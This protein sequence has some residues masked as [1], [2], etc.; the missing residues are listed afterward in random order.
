[1]KDESHSTNQ[2]SEPI[3]PRRPIATD[4]DPAELDDPNAGSPDKDPGADR[5]SQRPITDN[6][7][8]G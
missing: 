5:P 8:G 2:R 4:Q 6:K 1:M 7:A 3:E